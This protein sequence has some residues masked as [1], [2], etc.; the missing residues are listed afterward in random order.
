MEIVLRSA[1]VFLFLFAVTRAMGKKSLSEMSSFEVLL[2]VVL[3]DLVQQGLTERDTSVTGA[4]LAV[5]TFSLFVVALS[6][7]PLRFPKM[8]PAIE[9]IPVVIIH[10]GRF[11]HRALQIERLSEDEVIEA[12]REQGIGDL[13][14]IH[15]GVIEADGKFSF[16]RFDE[17][18]R[19][20][21]DQAHLG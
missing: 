21:E 7:L 17:E 4:F 2:L 6:Y 5:G 20:P 19:P 13:G 14:R 8:G 15:L 12:A 1:A 9:G 11:V 3:G 18:R 16:I 10:D